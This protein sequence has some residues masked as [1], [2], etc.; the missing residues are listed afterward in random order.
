MEVD[1]KASR[2][3]LGTNKGIVLVY[4]IEKSKYKQEY[5]YTITFEPSTLSICSLKLQDR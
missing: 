3:Y 4:D 1:Q 5:L 2:V